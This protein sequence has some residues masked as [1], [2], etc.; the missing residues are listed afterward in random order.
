M[1]A[2]AKMDPPLAK[3]KPT[4]NGGSISGITYLRRGGRKPIQNSVISSLLSPPL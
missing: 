1:P 4:S 2:G 3:A